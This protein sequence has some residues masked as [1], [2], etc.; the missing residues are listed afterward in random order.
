MLRPV[1]RTTIGL[2]I[3]WIC[4]ITPLRALPIYQNAVIGLPCRPIAV[5]DVDLDSHLDLVLCEGKVLLGDGKGNFPTPFHIPA[6][7]CTSMRDF[8]QDQIPDLLCSGSPANIL[9]GLG[10]GRYQDPSPLPVNGEVV[11][12]DFNSD[13][14]VD[15]AV[16]SGFLVLGEGRGGFGAPISLGFSGPLAVG[17]FNGDRRDDLL[18]LSGQQLQNLAVLLSLGNGLFSLAEISD[19]ETITEFE[20][21]DVD[22]DGISDIVYGRIEDRFV[23][24]RGSAWG[25]FHREETIPAISHGTTFVLADLNGDGN[26]D[27]AHVSYSRGGGVLLGQGNGLFL[28]SSGIPRR[29]AH[30]LNLDHGDVNGDGKEDLVFTTELVGRNTTAAVLLSEGNGSF[31]T[32]ILKEEHGFPATVGDVNFD[33][34]DDAVYLYPQPPYLTLFINRG[35]SD[36]EGQAIPWRGPIVAAV[37]HDMDADHLDDLIVL[38]ET[39]LGIARALGEGRFAPP[40][41]FDTPSPQRELR[42]IN[43]NH[44]SF[45]DALVY[46]GE[47]ICVYLGSGGISLSGPRCTPAAV[48]LFAVRTGDLNGDHISDFGAMSHIF[49]G[50]KLFLLEGTGDASFGEPVLFAQDIASFT[51]VDSNGDGVDELWIGEPAFGVAIRDFNADGT[52]DFLYY[53]CIDVGCL[54]FSVRMDIRSADET[55][56]RSIVFPEIGPEYFDFDIN[57]DFLT[58]DMNGDSGPDVLVWRDWSGPGVLLML[59]QEPGTNHFPVACAIGEGDVECQST[60]GAEVVLDGSSS[61]DTDSTPGSSDDVVS[62]GWYEDL[63]LPTMR[64]IGDGETRRTTLALG[65]HDISLLV[66]DRAGKPSIDHFVVNVVDTTSP[67]LEIHPSPNVLWPP[68][69]RLVPIRVEALATDSCGGARFELESIQSNEPLSD[70][71]GGA[72][73]V[74]DADFGTGDVNFQLRA[75]RLG[76]GTGRIYSV[77]YR[78]MDASG[79]PTSIESRIT[80]PISLSRGKSR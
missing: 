21:G 77:R 79:N 62:Y 11:S 53:D 1:Y 52:P 69:N 20:V 31:G 27:I 28:S 30:Y 36:F 51:F 15:V 55:L 64:F 70:S 67:R 4:L 66:R 58:A 37:L 56:P 65:A 10:A 25:E 9:L 71:S 68:D 74:V 32:H 44:D 19:F 16:S 46:S 80:V 54:M 61:S 49:E 3:A 45:P 59:N 23:L 57:K 47:E 63:G 5:L 43:A 78:A 72:P 50:G 7:G 48:G 26:L 41:F 35:E 8:N 12:G 29:E 33:G 76:N 2:S 17:D 6:D 22:K 13:G 60:S 40:L 38:D 75:E 34:L 73:D 24:V 14:D 42:V 18:T 39:G